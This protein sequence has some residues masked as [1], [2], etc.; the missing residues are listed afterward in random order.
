MGDL[1]FAAVNVSRFLDVD[2]EQSLSKACEKFISRFEQV[3]HLAQERGISMK[4]QP[5]S[6]LDKLWKEA[7]EKQK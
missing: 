3:E 1:F 4:E 5:L 2:P 7:K 6:E